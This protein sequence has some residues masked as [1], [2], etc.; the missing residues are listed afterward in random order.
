MSERR[1]AHLLQSH[2]GDL[3]FLPL[4][5]PSP[6]LLLQHGQLCLSF[7]GQPLQLLSLSST[8]LR[9]QL[10]ALWDCRTKRVIANLH[11]SVA[12]SRLQVRLVALPMGTRFSFFGWK[13]SL[14]VTV[15][16]RAL[17]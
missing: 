4:L 12:V 1:T 3:L 10:E 9:R 16:G 11:T 15:L 13:G 14:L 7:A 17:K 6:L 8:A 2:L 5:L